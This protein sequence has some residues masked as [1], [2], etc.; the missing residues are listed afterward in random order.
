MLLQTWC[1][2]TKVFIVC[3]ELYSNL[4][5]WEGGGVVHGQGKALALYTFLD[6][7]IKPV[8]PVSKFSTDPK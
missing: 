7:F 8:C 4:G 5:T 6:P 3:Y 1:D 2:K